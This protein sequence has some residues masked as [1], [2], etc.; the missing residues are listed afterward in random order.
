MYK[1]GA[2]LLKPNA[3]KSPAENGLTPGEGSWLFAEC[4]LHGQLFIVWFLHGPI[5]IREGAPKKMA[6]L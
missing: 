5:R 2:T 3:S 6:N 1:R 4:I